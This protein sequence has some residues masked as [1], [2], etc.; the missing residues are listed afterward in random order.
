MIPKIE[1]CNW[2]FDYIDKDKWMVKRDCCDDEILLIRDD[3]KNWK[4][5]R[6]SLKPYPLGC[7]PDASSMCPNCGKFVNSVNPYDDGETWMK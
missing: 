1:W 4:A 3:S 5:Y 2:A 6:A 7:Y